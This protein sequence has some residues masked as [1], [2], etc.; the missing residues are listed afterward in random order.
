MA[1]KSKRPGL[2]RKIKG[3]IFFKLDLRTILP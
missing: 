1:G 2:Y 3:K